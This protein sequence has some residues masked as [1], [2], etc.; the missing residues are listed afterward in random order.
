M[1]FG[2]GRPVP[3]REDPR[4]LTGRGRFVADI[5][6]ARQAYAVFIHAP[7]ACARIRSIDKAAAEQAPGVH[8][9]LTGNDW[10]A[11]GL[12]CLETKFMSE[13]VGGPK[14]IRTSIW[15]LARDRVRHVGE[16]VAVVIAA[17]ESGGIKQNDHHIAIAV[18]TAHGWDQR[19]RHSRVERMN[20]LVQQCLTTIGL[21]RWRRADDSPVSLRRE[22]LEGAT[23]AGLPPVKALLDKRLVL[24][25]LAG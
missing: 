6:L 25:S 24:G 3:R 1:R 20:H 15:P 18:E 17:T 9:I 4:F 22:K 2:I 16:R 7:H 13:D 14:G 21:R 23:R 5:D 10:A 8:A 19:R 11:A 12:G